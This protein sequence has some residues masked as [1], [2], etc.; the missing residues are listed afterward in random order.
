[1]QPE[2]REG[3]VGFNKIYILE[4]LFTGDKRTGELLFEGLLYRTAQQTEEFKVEYV[5]VR[6]KGELLKQLSRIH[7]NMKEKLEIPFLHIEM[8]GSEQGLHFESREIIT[9]NT[10][11]ASLRVINYAAN[12]N[13]LI[14]MASCFGAK[15]IRANSF[16]ERAPFGFL[17]APHNKVAEASIEDGF[18]RFFL[19]L[20]HNSDLGEAIGELNDHE[21]PGKF[22][23]YD[24]EGLFKVQWHN[25]KRQF[26]NPE[27]QDARFK[28]LYEKARG[29]YAL[30]A[31]KISED[32]FRDAVKR[33]LK[34]ED[35]EMPEKLHHYLLKDKLPPNEMFDRCVNV[36]AKKIKDENIEPEYL[37]LDVFESAINNGYSLDIVKELKQMIVLQATSAQIAMSEQDELMKL[38]K[39][40]YFHEGL[41]KAADGVGGDKVIET[42]IRALEEETDIFKKALIMYYEKYPERYYQ[43]FPERKPV[44]DDDVAV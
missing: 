26:E 30:D 3:F 8:H 43:D 44:A 1:M 25:F 6:T 15:L 7:D 14:T 13:L 22:S 32:V 12:N 38:M 21:K 36:F 42:V 17:I 28:E 41:I 2:H 29:Q 39:V 10:L 40:Y 18:K 31:H 11:A 16:N 5:Y 20:F 35:D 27:T 33:A 23:Y 19:K 24:A 34:E 37:S 9:W 4:S